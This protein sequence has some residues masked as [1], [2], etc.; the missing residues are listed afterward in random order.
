MTA[1]RRVA[2]GAR[3]GFVTVWTLVRPSLPGV[4]RVNA[5]RVMP[6]PAFDEVRDRWTENLRRRTAARPGAVV[7][8]EQSAARFVGFESKAVGVLQAGSIAA[9]GALLACSDDGVLPQTFGLVGLGYLTLAAAACC[10]VLIPRARTAFTVDE[11]LSPTAGHAEM[12]AAVVVMQ[13]QALMMSNLVT[14]AVY[15]L[16]RG[17]VATALA[18]LVVAL[19]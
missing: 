12:V 13:P 5:R 6:A 1:W 4:L 11:L 19:T 14:S 2:H 8:Y 3:R 15:D 10:L 9:A 7:L 18:L 16:A 17:A